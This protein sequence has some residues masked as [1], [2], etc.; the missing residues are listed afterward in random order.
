MHIAERSYPI[1]AITYSDSGQFEAFLTEVTDLMADAACDWPA[2]SS[3]ACGN[4][5]A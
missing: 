4:L 3:F 1:T 5:V 2:L